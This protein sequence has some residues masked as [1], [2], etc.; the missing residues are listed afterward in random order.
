MRLYR[1]SNRRSGSSVAH[2]C[3]LVWIPST[4]ASAS[5]GE[6]D[7]ALVFTGD[8]LAFQLQDCETC[9]VPSPCE[10]LSRSRTTT[11]PLP[12]ARAV[13][14]R[15]TCPLLAWM[16]RQEG[17]PRRFPRSPPPGYELGAQLCPGS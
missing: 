3:S 17:D 4:L 11:D 1:S 13:S 14:R 6:N 12:R 5:L 8:L 2:R 16:D 7:G 15:R 10:R 9:W